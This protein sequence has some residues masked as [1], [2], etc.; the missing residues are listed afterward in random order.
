MVQCPYCDYE[1]DSIDS[2]RGHIR[3]KTDSVHKGKSGFE[4]ETEQLVNDDPTGTPDPETVA[5]QALNGKDDG[6]ELEPEPENDP[7][8]GSNTGLFVTVLVGIALWI[9]KRYGD[10]STQ[11]GVELV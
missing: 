4:A 1:T 8:D 5:E 10:E 2:V 9:V 3:A 7:E 6:T 11:D